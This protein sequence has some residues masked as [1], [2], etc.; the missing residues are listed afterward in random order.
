MLLIL[1]MPFK[2]KKKDINIVV[3]SLIWIS[4][5]IICKYVEL[6]EDYRNVDE[7]WWLEVAGV[8]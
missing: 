4:M 1:R 7:C 6:V 3:L 2:K 5:F 8:G